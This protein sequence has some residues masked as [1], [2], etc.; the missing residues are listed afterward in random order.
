LGVATAPLID[1]M[2]EK[3][4]VSIT[5]SRK[6]CNSLASFLPGAAL[7]YLA[8]LEDFNPTLVTVLF[9]VAVGTSVFVQSGFL[10]N[11]LDVAPNHAGTLL[12]LIN[13]TNNI[14]S[15]LGPL[16]VGLL[17]SDKVNIDQVS[18]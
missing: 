16:S 12:G 6:I 15:I 8:F 9:V 1:R 18:K 5:T 2:I 4:T 13:G 11:V 7:M 14:F 17:G 10:I 3:N